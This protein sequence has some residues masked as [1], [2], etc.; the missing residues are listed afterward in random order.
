MLPALQKSSEE[1]ETVEPCNIMY[2]RRVVRGNTWAVSRLTATAAA[3]QADPK[4][5]RPKS[6]PGSRRALD[7][8]ST[9]KF[10]WI[11]VYL[12]YWTLNLMPL[13]VYPRILFGVN[14]HRY[15]QYLAYWRNTASPLMQLARHMATGMN[16]NPKNDNTNVEGI[17]KTVARCLV[18]WEQ[19]AVVNV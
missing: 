10:R 1:N 15:I 5:A 19:F 13:M 14:I 11:L 17:T 18:S 7:I 8:L 2:D 6:N 9:L 16:H 3:E 4:A 12:M